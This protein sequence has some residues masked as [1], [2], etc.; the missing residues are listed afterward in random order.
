V[1]F[2][3]VPS[4]VITTFAVADPSY[5]MTSRRDDV[6]GDW[7]EIVTVALMARMTVP[8][9]GYVCVVVLVGAGM[10]TPLVVSPAT[11]LAV[12]APCDDVPL[13]LSVPDDAPFT[14]RCVLPLA[15]PVI[16]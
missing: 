4:C 8:A 2:W 7:P 16:V 15:S 5:V 14:V 6:V 9:V 13:V 11:R 1:Q 3:V 12:N 10:T